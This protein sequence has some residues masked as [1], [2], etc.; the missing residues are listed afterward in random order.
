MADRSF[1]RPESWYALVCRPS[2]PKDTADVLDLTKDIW[3]GHDYVPYVWQDWLEDTTG[4]L[5]VAEYGG[6]VVGM[7][8]LTRLDIGQW[9]L[10]GLR[11]HPSSQGRGIGSRLH[12]YALGQ[13]EQRAGG[14]LRLATASFRH[15][16]Q[17]LCDRTGFDKVAEF[18]AYRSEPLL[19]A[20]KGGEEPFTPVRVDEAPKALQFAQEAPSTALSAGLMDLGWQWAAPSEH[21]LIDAVERGHAW[22]WRKAQKGSYGLLLVNEDE[23]DDGEEWQGRRLRIELLACQIEDSTALL[24]DYRRLAA[25]LSM[26]R[27]DWMAPVVP[28][29]SSALDAAGFERDWEH[30]LYLYAKV[31][32]SRDQLG[33]P[34]MV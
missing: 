14:T 4:V 6:K 1:L 26:D 25:R 24:D 20:F 8:K 15:S 28:E 10:E 29:L 9:W 22:W 2:L 5:A 12:E 7:G 23:V 27:A 30:S 16:V 32:A 11:V 21:L 13:W 19:E 3:D 31:G 33:T 34:A 17:H 18:T